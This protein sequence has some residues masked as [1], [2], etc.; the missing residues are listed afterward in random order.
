MTLQRFSAFPLLRSWQAEM[1]G[2]GSLYRLRYRHNGQ[3]R[4]FKRTDRRR[5]PKK[6]LSNGLKR[7]AWANPRSTLSCATGFFP[8]ALLG[9]AHSHCSL[10]RMRICCPARKR[11]AAA[12]P[13]GGV[14]RAHRQRR[15][16]PCENRQLCKHHLPPLRRP[17]QERNRHHASMGG[18]VVVFP[19]LLRSSQ[20]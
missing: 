9:R 14:L 2:K 18:F 3:F 4:L 12:S 13:R 1:C 8:S 11:A 17:R 16:A 7:K 19:S 15:V 6:P 10:R 5:G 20:R